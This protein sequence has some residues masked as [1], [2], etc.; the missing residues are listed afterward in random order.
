MN[1]GSEQIKSASMVCEGN[2]ISRGGLDSGSHA[3]LAGFGTVRFSLKL[4]NLGP[5]GSR[6]GPLKKHAYMD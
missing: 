1:V 3:V 6:F 2:T 5:T 4:P